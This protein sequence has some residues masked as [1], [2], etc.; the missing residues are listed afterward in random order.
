MPVL[1]TPRI[2]NWKPAQLPFGSSLWSEASN[3]GRNSAENE[4]S[5]SKSDLVS[6]TPSPIALSSGLTIAPRKPEVAYVSTIPAITSFD[7]LKLLPAIKKSIAELGFTTPSPV[8]AQ[9][10]P[11]LLGDP[12]DFIGLAATGTGKTAAFAIPLLERIDPLARHVQAIILC[13]TRELAIQVAG[14]VELLGKYLGVKA[15]TIYGG[16]G[17]G[18]QIASLRRG[19]QVVVGTPGRVIDHLDKGTLDLSNVSIVILDEADEMI[20]MGFKEEMESILSNIP[21]LNEEIAIGEDDDRSANIWLF[22]ATMSRE[23]RNV[24]DQYLVEPAR[25]EINKTEMLPENLEQSYF[26]TSESNKPE[27]LCKIIDAAD[28]FYGIIFCQ[29]KSLVV[30]LTQY[31]AGRGYAVDCLHGD[32]DQKARERTMK[33][34]RERKVMMLVCTDVAS[35]GIDV[36]DIT[37]VINYS[38]PRE[39]DSYI[40]RIGRTARSGKKGY[41]M[42][43]VTPSHRGLLGR[44]ERVTKSRI[45]EGRIPTRKEVGAKK[46]G[47]ALEKLEAV[48]NPARA[49]EL[50][51][52]E[53]R[54]KFAGMT[55]E[56]VVGRYLTVVLPEAFA[57]QREEKAS[58]QYAPPPGEFVNTAP[59]TGKGTVIRVG[60]AGPATI[61]GNGLSSES[62][63]SERSNRFYAARKGGDER[64]SGGPRSYGDRKPA[65]GAKPSFGDR[66]PA[67]GAKPSFGA[68]PAY[69]AKPAFGG[70]SEAPKARK[71]GQPADAAPRLPGKVGGKVGRPG[72]FAVKSK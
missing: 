60:G 29:T 48:T 50:V 67:Y 4:A 20:S 28:E 34:F 52:P 1:E 37:H 44:I 5:L 12:T 8:Q 33:N 3:R 59:I 18:D 40:H 72:V 61:G 21:G 7:E 17:Y 36:K 65:Y 51:S 9:A 41:A 14:Q 19:A 10:L 71:W 15:A 46:I 27:V 63:S 64:R 11:I 13:P 43:L 56:E 47:A 16:A 32:M 42:S 39:M 69:G 68:K 26:A 49:M 30:D 62:D 66:K 53:L 45:L 24:S 58:T 38:I 55:V 31:L 22:S 6:T 54:A 2:L 35:R 23:V 70:A 25:V 57:E